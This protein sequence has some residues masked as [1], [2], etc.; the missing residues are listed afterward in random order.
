MTANGEENNFRDITVAH[1]QTKGTASYCA[2][3]CKDVFSIIMSSQIPIQLRGKLIQ[4]DVALMS[5]PL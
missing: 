1:I 3:E 4:S 5:V 2:P